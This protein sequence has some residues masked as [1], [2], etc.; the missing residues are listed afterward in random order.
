MPYAP[1]SRTQLCRLRAPVA[2]Q[3]QPPRLVMSVNV[4]AA[5]AKARPTKLPRVSV[6]AA[7]E[8]TA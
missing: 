2:L 5:F 4:I 8:R 1:G 7:P 6:M 3:T